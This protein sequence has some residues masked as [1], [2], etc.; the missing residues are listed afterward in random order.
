MGISAFSHCFIIWKIISR[1]KLSH[2]NW[3]KSISSVV[4]PLPVTRETGVQFPDGEVCSFVPWEMSKLELFGGPPIPQS[5]EYPCL[6]CG[7]F[8]WGSIPWRGDVFMSNIETSVYANL[9]KWCQQMLNGPVLHNKRVFPLLGSAYVFTV[10]L[11]VKLNLKT[12][13]RG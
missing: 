11:L 2:S 7:R 9:E 8:D 12:H 3:E 6:S 5:G 4:G 1:Q 10:P 13:P